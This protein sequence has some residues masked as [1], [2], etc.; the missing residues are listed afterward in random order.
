[1]FVTIECGSGD[2]TIMAM[3]D[4]YNF[5]LKLRKNTFMHDVGTMIGKFYAGYGTPFTIYFNG[6][7]TLPK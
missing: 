2:N 5:D 3:P 6:T 7:T 4:T 1:M